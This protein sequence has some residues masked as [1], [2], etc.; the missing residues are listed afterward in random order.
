[1]VEKTNTYDYSAFQARFAP[2]RL[3]SEA[4]Y[5]D[6]S[7]KE[8]GTGLPILYAPGWG[9]HSS[10]LRPIAS[11]FVKQKKRTIAIGAPHGI[12]TDAQTD[13]SIPE[14]RKVAS[15][16]EVM[17]QTGV[18]KVDAVAHSESGLSLT[19]AALEHPEM[20]RTIVLI[21]SGGLMEN[22]TPFRVAKRTVLDTLKDF[23]SRLQSLV[24]GKYKPGDASKTAHLMR[25]AVMQQPIS[26]ASPGKSLAEIGYI[27]RGDIRER[28]VQLREKG[29]KVI[30]IQ[31][32]EDGAFP[33]DKSTITAAHYD[34]RH[35][36]P[37]RHNELLTDPD[38][39]TQKA[40]EAIDDCNRGEPDLRPT[41]A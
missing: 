3:N 2:R 18:S 22:D 4:E 29:V 24:T 21:N 13:L 1:M 6:A 41:A 35:I 27:G 11:S 15:I 34:Q 32:S 38:T 5:I 17:R 8:G 33:P 10:V 16:F 40:L 26:S 14:A 30:I 31:T 9:I 36:M 20:F 12:H 7:P 25:M 28:L 19:A 23:G 37:G 39:F